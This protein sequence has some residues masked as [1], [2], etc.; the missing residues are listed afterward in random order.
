MAA[1]NSEILELLLKVAGA[2]DVG[3]L[4]EALDK[5]GTE[6][7]ENAGK[8]DALTGELEKLTTTAATAADA[9]RLKAALKET[10]DSLAAAEKGLAELNEEFTDT[11]KRT[12]AVG[13][14]FK[15]AEKAVADLTKQQREQ[16]LALKRSNGALQK[17]G[18]D[19]DKLADETERLERE[20]LDATKATTKQAVG[21]KASRDA[22]EKQAEAYD[23][24]TGSLR[25]AG[26]RL[27]D[28]GGKFAAVGAAAA[29]A[30]ASLAVYG[31]AK[32]FAA[33]LEDAGA[34][35]SALGRIQAAA[36]LTADEM[37]GVKEAIEDTA[38]A[39]SIARCS[40]SPPI[41]TSVKS[42]A[43]GWEGSGTFPKTIRTSDATNW[44]SW[45]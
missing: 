28:I 39:A 11:G 45:S 23:K 17:A 26:S 38:A 40:T 8:T 13:Q 10:T 22:A 44:R 4:R 5:L 7:T 1:K 21:L 27:N 36:G 42:L 30:A 16:E 18:V 34:F 12:G 25:N 31:T 41:R 14:Q 33:G 29:A 2:E 43:C 9:I 24:L 35:E 3:K 32:F 20:I 37:G 15:A 6:A 19:T